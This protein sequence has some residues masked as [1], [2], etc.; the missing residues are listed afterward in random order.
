M[1]F[2]QQVLC[3]SKNNDTKYDNYKHSQ[4]KIKD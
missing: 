2:F 4:N 3:N 1:G